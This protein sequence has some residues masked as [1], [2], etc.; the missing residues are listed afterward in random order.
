MPMFSEFFIGEDQLENLEQLFVDTEIDRKK[1]ML[2]VPESL[3]K[4]DR[5]VFKRLT[6]Y[7]EAGVVLVLDDYYPEDT[8]IELVREIGFTHVRI[9]KDSIARSTA[10]EL[11]DELLEHG[12][13][14]VEWPVG[15][16]QLTEDE[17]I[18][19]MVNHE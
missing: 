16:G 18:R 5:D 15:E 7:M 17:L 6:K 3:L 8:A 1:L 9:S 14:M 19:Y 11:M 2:S 10:K 4:E 12:I 13:I